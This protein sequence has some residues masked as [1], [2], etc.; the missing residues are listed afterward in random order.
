MLRTI[1]LL[2]AF[3]VLLIGFYSCNNK[4]AD[5]FDTEIDPLYTITTPIFLNSTTNIISLENFIKDFKN[6]D[7]IYYSSGNYLYNSTQKTIE[8]TNDFNEIDALSSINIVVGNKTYSIVCRKSD[9]AN[10][11]I[12]FI[13]KPSEKFVNV[14]IAGDFND[15]D[16][17]KTPMEFN[18]DCW[19]ANLR[20]DKGTYQYQLVVDG[21]WRNNH[22][23]GDTVLN[24]IGGYNT[25]LSVQSQCKASAPQIYTHSYNNQEIIIKTNYTPDKLLIL[26]QN[27]FIPIDLNNFDSNSYTIQIP[28]EAKK[29]QRSDIRIF[30]SYKGC[31]SNDLLIPLKNGKVITS[32]Q[33]LSRDDKHYNIMYFMLVDR[34]FNKCKENDKPLH[35]NRLPNKS[36]YQGGDLQGINHK[37]ETGYFEDLGINCLWISSIFQNPTTA[38][39]E[40]SEPRRYSSGYHG[41]WPISSVDID[42]RFGNDSVFKNLIDN[43]HAQN[44]NIILDFVANHVHQDHPLYQSNKSWAT[45]LNLPDGRKN[46][47]IWN[48]YRLTTWFDTFLPSWDFNNPEVTDTISE[49][50]LYWIKKF[51][52][53][54]FRHDATKH[55]P[56]V[57]WTNLT[58]KIQTNFSEKTFFQI[59][60]TFGSRELINN[61][62]G[63]DKLD[64]QFDFNLYF[65]VRNCFADSLCDMQKLAQSL[66]SSL[67]LYG[68]NNLMGNITGNH[69]IIRF[70]TYA[71]KS[72][73]SGEDN[74]EAG[75]ARDINVKNK[76][77]YKKLQNLA[78]FTMS[79]PGIPCIYYGDEIGMPGAGDPDNR[80]MMIFDNLNPEQK[81]TFE[82]FKKLISI[83]KNNIELIYGASFIIHESKNALVLKRQYFDKVSYLLINQSANTKELTLNKNELGIINEYAINFNSEINEL[84]SNYQIILAPY[85][86][87]LLTKN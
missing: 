67:S 18:D 31:Q 1:N 77:S 56:E 34:F 30:S 81:E 42:I 26:W 40:F 4:K 82:I 13:P 19:K 46:I 33:E 55:I 45:E 10:I 47:R 6:I 11:T 48:E 39:K 59:G 49:L 66:N 2:F 72:V 65:D 38:F 3:Q 68:Y 41:Y 62:V 7:S 53:D 76:L 37:L 80:R 14:K 63:S 78:A 29:N 74:K 21:V 60:E 5:I 64:G 23:E 20:L 79:I 61:Y 25:L 73:L 86:F 70:I 9:K 75:W 44:T 50:A 17:D 12:N 32:T 15:W 43:A 87:E 22:P 51:D 16:P 84:S 58:K 28:E 71:D 24:G 8:I 57:F 54:G 83:R 35:D 36:N 52:V 85:S 69:N 27:Q